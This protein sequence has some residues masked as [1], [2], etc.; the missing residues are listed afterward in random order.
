MKGLVVKRAI[1][2]FFLTCSFWYGSIAGAVSPTADSVEDMPMGQDSS[3]KESLLPEDVGG[4]QG[5]EELFGVEGGY[6]HPYI[7][8]DVEYTDN[9]YNIDEGDT[10]NVLTR[11]SPGVWFALPRK[12]IIPISINSRNSSPG[13][14]LS[15]FGDYQGTDRYQAYLLGNVDFKN[16]SADSDLNS[17]DGLLEGM[18]RYNMRGG[19]SLQVV[20]RFTHGQDQFEIGSK[21]RGQLRRYDANFF[22]ATAD[23]D[24]TEKLRFQLDFF[25]FA[26]NYDAAIN[27]FLNRIDNGLNLYG[28]YNYSLIT[29][30]FL[31]YK[32]VDVAYDYNKD[33]DNVS[34]YIY[35][36][37]KWDTTEKI[38]LLAKIGYQGKKFDDST[39]GQSDYHGFALDIQLKYR[40]TEK[41]NALLDVYRNNEETDSYLASDKTVFGANFRYIQHFTDKVSGTLDCVFE[42]SK[43]SNIN[44]FT[45][46]GRN[47]L[48][49]VINPGIQYLFREW[50][51]FE[52]AYKFDMRDSDNN[53]F[54][55]DSN[56]VFFNATFAL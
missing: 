48:A 50:L 19:L 47:D 55:Y 11:I 26:L 17:T 51:K 41:T 4:G 53:L 8:L 23:W 24:L 49:F 37:I 1:F 12:K 3:G 31:E 7:T 43:Y 40:F 34:N 56:T 35:G 54:D 38:A 20:D 33:L 25:D 22:M 16:Y 10:S 6:F 21:S 45:N 52:L 32:F 44:K 39:L 9:L 5:E 36:G 42:N 27:K 29:A 14:L 13:G 46:E 15:Q 2:V 30:F 28:Y 18:F